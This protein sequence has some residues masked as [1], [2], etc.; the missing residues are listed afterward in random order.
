VRELVASRPFLELLTVQRGALEREVLALLKDRC[1]RYGAHGLGVTFDG[2]SLHDLHP[3]QE[4]VPAYHEVTKAMEVRDKLINEAQ[5][6]AIRKDREAQAEALRIERKALANANEKILFAES[7]RDVFLARQRARTQIGPRGE[8]QLFSEAAAGVAQGQSPTFAFHTYQERRQK[9]LATQ[10]ALTDFRLFWDT[11]TRALAGRDK[12][13]IDA[14]RLPGKRQ[15]L[16]WEQE[17]LRIPLPSM[18]APRG[19]PSAPPR[20]RGEPPEQ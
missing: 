17:P 8:W 10:A 18:F 4:V 3:P 14:D 13:L 6:E 12:I 19:S 2:L 7:A 15:L 16:L 11:L 20:P 9:V 1:Q 5:A